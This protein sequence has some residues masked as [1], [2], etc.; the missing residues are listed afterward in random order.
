MNIK[1]TYHTF[2]YIYKYE[3][4]LPPTWYWRLQKPRTALWGRHTRIDLWTQPESVGVTL[5]IKFIPEKFS[6]LLHNCSLWSW[7]QFTLVKDKWN[8]VLVWGIIIL[9]IQA[10]QI[11]FYL[12]EFLHLC[13]PQDTRLPVMSHI[14]ALPQSL[15]HHPVEEFAGL[16]SEP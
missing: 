7:N 1:T 5:K 8:N 12:T 6:K 4:N 11:S 14:P 16:W 3:H 2:T 13:N 10:I 15:W 9:A